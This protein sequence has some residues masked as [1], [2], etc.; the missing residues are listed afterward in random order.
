MTVY[1]PWTQRIEVSE[2]TDPYSRATTADGERTLTVDLDS[3]ALQPQGWR[4]YSGTP[5]HNFTD[6]SVY[7]LHI[8]DFSATDP[9]VLPELRGLYRAFCPQVLSQLPNTF[10]L[11]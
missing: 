7:E 5:V 4:Q 2:V 10:E 8:R 11:L 6:I 1:C 9:T 3:S